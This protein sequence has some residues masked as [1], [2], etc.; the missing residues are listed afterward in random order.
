MR[1]LPAPP[2][3]IGRLKPHR[4][5]RHLAHCDLAARS[6]MLRDGRIVALIDR[7]VDG[8][9]TEYWE[10]ARFLQFGSKKRAI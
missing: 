8:W 1:A 4:G 5:R 3:F 6:I 7:E 9:Y 2:N 10:Y